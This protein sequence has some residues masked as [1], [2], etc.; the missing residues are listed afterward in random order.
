M[1]LLRTLS[2]LTWA[3]CSTI[4]QAEEGIATDRPDFVES[5]DVVDKGRVQLELGVNLERSRSAGQRGRA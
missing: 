1:K 3:A 2:C 4:A 5:S